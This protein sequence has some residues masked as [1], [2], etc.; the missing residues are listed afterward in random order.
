[1][2][3]FRQLSIIILY[4]A[5]KLPTKLISI[6][7]ILG[8]ITLT[9][10]S[11]SRQTLTMSS[12]G[13][14][15]AYERIGRQIIT[16]AQ[17]VGK[18]TVRD[19]HDSPGS[20]K[21]LERLLSG[22][23]DLALVQLDVASEAMTTG[24]VQAIVVLAHEYLHIITQANSEIET[25]SDL[26][27][28]RVAIGPPGSGIYF[29]AK[30]VFSAT[31]LNI[32]EEQI[33]FD[34]AFNKVREQQIDAMVY[35][36][37]LGS[38]KKIQAELT[39]APLLRLI[40]IE[41]ALIN[42]L[43]IQF[44]ESYQSAIFP[45]GSYVPLRPLP[46]EDLPTISTAAALVTRPN[47]SKQ[48]IALLTWSILS[49]SRQYSLFYPELADGNADSLL[50]NGLVF[51]HPGSQQA[52]NEG[53]PREVWVRYLE[54]NQ[55][56]QAGVIIVISTG[57]IGF[58]LRMWRQKRCQNFIKNSRLALNEISDNVETNP[59]Q[60]LKEVEELR[61]QHRLMLIEG[62]LPKEAY[63]KLEKMTQVIAE[64]CRNLQ[65]KQRQANI[66]NTL[67]LIE[68]WQSF[69]KFCPEE[70]KKKLKELED[71]YRELLLSRQI[72]L[73]TYINLKQL[74]NH[75]VSVNINHNIPTTLRS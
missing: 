33:R 49:S 48:T 67:E 13:N 5:N 66:R 19:N 45:Q 68:E 1:M 16:S 46:S 15:G 43:T 59:S 11:P 21:N 12:G 30:R 26:Q 2:Q 4:L 58:L 65:E 69:S 14:G 70:A 27:G 38:S 74:I 23:I 37:P 50:R 3:R 57:I 56:L 54:E 17:E 72:D 39:K 42:Y 51:L 34:E 18:I 55:D 61:Q 35:V 41:K 73:Q 10:C 44:P 71:K 75:H 47:I 64:Q 32:V 6:G 52:F 53:D 60:T 9:G 24:K 8:A 22:E 36:G 29:T 31:N 7:G 63:E 25:L 62:D 40:P 20:Q 28:K